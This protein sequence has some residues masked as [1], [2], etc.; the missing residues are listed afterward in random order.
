M[1]TLKTILFVAGVI[2]AL[3]GSTAKTWAGGGSVGFVCPPNVLV[4]NPGS[5]ALALRGTMAAEAHNLLFDT[6][7]NPPIV[8]SATDVD[9]ILRLTRAGVTHFFRKNDPGPTNDY[10]GLTN[11]NILCQLIVGTSIKA[12]ILSEFGIDPAWRLILT[13]SSVSNADE[14][15]IVGGSLS[16]I[17]DVTIYA[18]R[19]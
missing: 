19:P 7:V 10:A 8:I 3:F 18:V 6:S 4:S 17:A 12:D 15:D 2:V 14:P 1:K 9:F 5:G 13:P 11:L 16:G